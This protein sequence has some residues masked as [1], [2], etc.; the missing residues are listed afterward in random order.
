M[1]D[2]TTSLRPMLAPDQHVW[3]D[4][5]HKV[6]DAVPAPSIRLHD[7]I[8]QTLQVQGVAVAEHRGKPAYRFDVEDVVNGGKGRVVLTTNAVVS[9]V[10]RYDGGEG[11]GDSPSAAEITETLRAA[12]A[13]ARSALEG[14]AVPTTDVVELVR[15]WAKSH[16]DEYEDQSD[17]L[18]GML[19]ALVGDYCAMTGVDTH[20]ERA[21]TLGSI[22]A[23]ICPGWV[24]T[25]DT[26]R[27]AE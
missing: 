7:V 12:N 21:Y 16:R 23:N 15:E 19:C 27:K 18:F 3:D 1:T 8:A 11:E 24:V 9:D 25:D 17:A 4:F 14:T 22:V 10:K 13:R 6:W 2:T 20:Q 26:A 5:P